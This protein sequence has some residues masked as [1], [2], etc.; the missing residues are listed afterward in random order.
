[1]FEDAFN[2]VVV[3]NYWFI[4]SKKHANKV[5][6]YLSIQ[7]Q[8]EPESKKLKSSSETVSKT[9]T[10]RLF[11]QK[12]SVFLTAGWKIKVRLRSHGSDR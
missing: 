6:R 12:C 2:V 9:K 10:Q 3:F 7:S 11:R 1:M 4:Q 8:K 5:R